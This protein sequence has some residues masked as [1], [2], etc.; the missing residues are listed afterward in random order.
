M[1]Y[2]NLFCRTITSL[3]KSICIW[4][5]A[6]PAR[7]PFIITLSLIASVSSFSEGFN[8][9]IFAISLFCLTLNGKVV[10]TRNTIVLNTI[11][12]HHGKEEVA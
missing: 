5:R 10:A 11:V 9:S 4:F 7:C 6:F 1:F 8:N 12:A 3:I 2:I